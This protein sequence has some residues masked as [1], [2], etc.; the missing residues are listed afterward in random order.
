MR[1]PAASEMARRCSAGGR[2]I[3]AARRN[4]V[5]RP[6]PAERGI[7]A[8]ATLPWPAGGREL[9]VTQASSAPRRGKAYLALGLVLAVTAACSGGHGSGHRPS[10]AMAVSGRSPFRHCTFRAPVHN[11]DSTMVTDSEVEPSL[12][13]SPKDSNVIIGVYQQDRWTGGQARG[14][15]AG[16]S[17]DGGRTWRHVPLPL[18]ACARRSV[19]FARAVDPWVAIG[20][21]GTA[22]AI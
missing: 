14:I 18:S 2:R 17:H 10:S 1:V 20:P 13:V 7:S 11:P 19:P 16:V 4:R 5:R 22:Y 9:A 21:D 12:A 15:V 8:P 6:R 3:L